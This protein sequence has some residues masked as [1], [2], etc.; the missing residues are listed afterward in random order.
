M[1]VGLA[2]NGEPFVFGEHFSPQFSVALIRPIIFIES[3]P[4]DRATV[5]VEVLFC[6]NPV[7]KALNIHYT[8]RIIRFTVECNGIASD[9]INCFFFGISVNCISVTQKKILR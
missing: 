5:F 7:V 8:D 1:D 6:Y 4:E 3:A 9:N 2:V